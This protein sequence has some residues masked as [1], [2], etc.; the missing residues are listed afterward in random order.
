MP[1]PVAL[2]D[3][4]EP[5]RFEDIAAWV[6]L[7]NKIVP[8]GRY[9]GIRPSHN[10][11]ACQWQDVGDWGDPR[12]LGSPCSHYRPVILV[13]GDLDLAD[14][15]GQ[16]VLIV[17]GNL[18]LEGDFVFAGLILVGVDLRIRGPG[19][20]VV[21]A[22]QVG[23]PEGGVTTHLAGEVRI[24]YAPCLV[25]QGMAAAGPAVPLPSRAWF[26]PAK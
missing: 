8:P 6:L 7:T 13:R 19:T 14:G 21:G 20:R 9:V 5:N 25:R 16:G 4:E 18:L 17:E 22:I 26:Y 3:A 15:V 10:G 23:G 11:P 24:D 12:T 2:E 1:L